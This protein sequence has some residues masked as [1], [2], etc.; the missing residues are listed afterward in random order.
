M[1]FY[2]EDV[3]AQSK[4]AAGRRR[5]GQTAPPAELVWEG[6][7]ETKTRKKMIVSTLNNFFFPSQCA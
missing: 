3:K 2:L 6:R 4:S 7:P 1:R 5:D